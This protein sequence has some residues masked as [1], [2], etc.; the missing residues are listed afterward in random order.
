MISSC[1]LTSSA[2][3]QSRRQTICSLNTASSNINETKNYSEEPVGAPSALVVLEEATSMVELTGPSAS[4]KRLNC[5][6][7]KCCCPEQEQKKN[8]TN[9]LSKYWWFQWRLGR[10]FLSKTYRE[11]SFVFLP[12]WNAFFFVPLTLYKLLWIPP[13]HNT[14]SLFRKT[15]NGLRV[16]RNR[17]GLKIGLR[18]IRETI[19]LQRT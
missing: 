15:K 19:C 13:A 4:K 1:W 18:G 17:L 9:E 10:W 6:S 7:S 14:K 5:L 12:F 16:L 11:A 8:P 3:V 2:K